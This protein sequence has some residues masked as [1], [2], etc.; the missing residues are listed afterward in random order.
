MESWYLLGKT[1]DIRNS[2]VEPMQN[3]LI[4]QKIS[5]KKHPQTALICCVLINLESK[6]WVPDF[7]L[8]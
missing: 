5:Q 7:A 3:L 2:E 8:S 6:S 4:A 1:S